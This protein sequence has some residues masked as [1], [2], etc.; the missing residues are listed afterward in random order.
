MPSSRLK[1]SAWSLLFW[2]GLSVSSPGQSALIPIEN[3]FA[4]ADI[5]SPELSPDGSRLAF[6]TTLGTGKVGIA[7]M[8]TATGKVEPLVAAKDENIEYFLWKGNDHIVYAGDVGGNESAALRT[9]HLS[10][11]RVI[12][13]AESFNEKT[14][15]RANWARIVDVLPLDP[16]HLLILGPKSIGSGS[17]DLWMLDVRD[18]KRRTVPVARGNE[19]VQNYVADNRG[20][21]RVR[22]RFAG[23]K[24]L[25]E[26]R[27]PEA[28][29]D[30]AQ[31]AEFPANDSRW[32]L[33]FF[34]A[35][36]ENLYLLSQA[37]S[38][39]PTLHT[40][41][42]RTL[43]L[44]E[45]IYRPATGEISSI[46]TDRERTTLRGVVYIDDRARY[47]WFDEARA[48][49]QAQID[50]TLPGTH[51]SVVSRSDDEQLLIVAASS[52]RDP[53]T[54]Y[55]LDRRA[56]RLMALG[57]INPRID[58]AQMRPMEP[59]KFTSRDG[60]TIHGYLTRPAGD[61]PAPLIV[62][63]HGGPF[64]VRDTWGFN[65]EVQFLA[66]RGYAVLQINFRGSS[67]YGDAFLKAGR[68]EWGGKMQ[69][70][71]TDGVQW[72]I[73]QKIA[74][75]TRIAIYGASYG[76]YAALAGVTFTPELYRCAINY[77]GVSDLNIINSWGRG[78]SGRASNQFFEEWVGD[79]KQYKFDRSPVNFVDRIRVPTLHAYGYN[80]PRVEIEHW[81][82]LEPKLK[83]FN[84]PYEA[85]IE[86]D[87][88]HG[89]DNEPARIKFY[90]QVEDFLARH[91]SPAI[92]EGNVHLGPAR[93][94]E[95]PVRN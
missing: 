14:A 38:D 25:I 43:K 44:S 32:N 91:L 6:L 62:H 92:P 67:G 33:L 37:Q 30:W 10:K 49:L 55:I 50:A 51:N 93:V 8:H 89:F 66:S 45:P 20:V 39:T 9:F 21:I 77:V 36:N 85:I 94:V 68:R 17:I 29:A 70:D 83:Q 64:G 41:N 58:P 23:D 2:I 35:D 53:G 1:H 56:P 61:G 80:D 7:L 87:E 52:D 15:D 27:P 40:L 28:K 63:P 46:I 3:F 22:T 69:D 75:P 24:Y 60:L 47:H 4:E 90:R 12:P 57:K 78:R 13:L 16:N 76:G 88:G 84:R 71:L 5:R 18:G 34:A 74:D 79:D 11:R 73:A 95:Q 65:P 48:R 31:V 82:R 81:L 54:Y 42:T 86:K 59:I 26:V 19:D 72:A